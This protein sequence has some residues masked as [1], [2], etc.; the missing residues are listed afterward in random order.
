MRE[1]WLPCALL[2]AAS[3]LAPGHE[4]SAW[5]EEWHSE[6]WYIPRHRTRFCLGAF[7]DA[8]WLRRNKGGEREPVGPALESPLRCLAILG[9]SAAIAL[10]MAVLLPAERIALPIS[11]L[12]V[13][14]LPAGCAAMLLLSGLML[15]AMRL[16]MGAAPVTRHTSWPGRLRRG[17]FL[18]L[19]IALL[20]PLL[21]CGLLVQ[22][23][24]SPIVPFAPTL[25]IFAVWLLAFR[26]VLTD[27]RRRCP[28][29]LRLLTDPVRI[30]NASETFLQWYGAESICSR[31]HGLLH[32]PEWATSYSERQEWFKLD[33]SW[34]SL[35]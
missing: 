7:R 26:W 24:L 20:Q 18:A 22:A 8:L 16:V 1:K 35:S 32:A 30:G 2:R 6:L 14:D 5:L 15:P 27:Q 11:H 9:A 12:R 3:F 19:K 25:G 31:G 23:W 34:S 28:V 29:C 21:L 13:R 4:R 17:I 10:L 33:S